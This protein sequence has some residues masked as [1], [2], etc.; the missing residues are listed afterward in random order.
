MQKGSRSPTRAEYNRLK[1]DCERLR[2]E[3][4][5]LRQRVLEQSHELKVQFTRIAEIQAILDE[6]R[7]TD[8][9]LHTSLPPPSVIPAGRR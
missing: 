2:S 6:E 1:A 4:E 5:A 8:A 3:M 9:R 7:M